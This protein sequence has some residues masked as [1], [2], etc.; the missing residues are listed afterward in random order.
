MGDVE[1]DVKVEVVGL[2]W[3]CNDWFLVS[4]G[5]LMVVLIGEWFVFEEVKGV[6][7]KIKVKVVEKGVEVLD[8]VV[9]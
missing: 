9:K 6:G 5:D 7:D 2:S 8:E 3:V 1:L 4:G